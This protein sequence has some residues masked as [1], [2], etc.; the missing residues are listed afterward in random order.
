M[1]DLVAAIVDVSDRL[2]RGVFSNEDQV[3]KGVVMRLLQ[4]LGWDVYDPTRVSSEFAIGSKKVDYALRHGPFGS[5]VLIEVKDVGKATSKGED[6]L[7][8]YCR[9]EGVPVAVLTDGRVWNFYW[10]AGRRSYEQR[11]FAVVNLVEGEP[12]ASASQ[13]LRYLAFD[14]VA[15]GRFEEDA[16]EDH[17]ANQ[18][19]IVAKQQLP[20]AFRS[21][22]ADSDPRV[23]ALFAD[24]VE[25]RCGKRPVEQDIRSFLGTAVAQS[26]VADSIPA[27]TPRQ[28]Q[29]EM[30]PSRKESRPRHVDKTRETRVPS[31]AAPDGPSFTLFGSAVPCRSDKEVLV[32]GLRALGKHDPRLYE[33]LAPRLAARSRSFLSRNRDQIYPEG[34]AEQILRAVEELP[35]G[36]WLG[37]HSSTRTKSDQLKKAREVAGLAAS[38]FKWQMKGK[39]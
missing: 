32:G 24:E 14:A 16:Q 26:A 3:S 23:V 13:L 9:G 29:P 31:S 17:K 11:R 19:R 2:R 1:D 37:T 18:E 27:P 6:Q 22:I 30:S 8:D 36:W 25:S 4:Q 39:T 38:Q 10:T 20:A 7:F 34:S 21:L 35:G 33:R 15:S 5:A 12:T 28:R